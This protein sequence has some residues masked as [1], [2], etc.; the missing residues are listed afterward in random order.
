MVGTNTM[1]H[2]KTAEALGLSLP[3]FSSPTPRT[4]TSI[5][6]HGTL[7]RVC[8]ERKG[9]GLCYFYRTLNGSLRF[10]FSDPVTHCSQNSPPLSV[11]SAK[12]SAC[13]THLSLYFLI[14]SFSFSD[15]SHRNPSHLMKSLIFWG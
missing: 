14:G 2:P 9:V 10:I 15:I 7:Y 1:V 12:Y 3:L 13:V 8:R 5:S 6:L 4:N 11:F